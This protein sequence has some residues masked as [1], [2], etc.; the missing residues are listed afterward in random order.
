MMCG[1]EGK[2]VLRHGAGQA[3]AIDDGVGFDPGH[4]AEHVSDRAAGHRNQDRP[5][6]GTSPL[7]AAD[8]DF[9]RRGAMHIY[10]DWPGPLVGGNLGL[11]GRGRTRRPLA[12]RAPARCFLACCSSVPGARS[13]ANGTFCQPVPASGRQHFGR[14]LTALRSRRIWRDASGVR[15]AGSGDA[16]SAG[17]G[18][19]R[20]SSR[21][22]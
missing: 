5:G 4:G 16:R 14:S 1:A 13:C 7:S 6:A 3:G 10:A 19:G 17:A 2:P 15:D 18:A 9:S 12:S 20:R 11:P 21:R 8:E 22:R